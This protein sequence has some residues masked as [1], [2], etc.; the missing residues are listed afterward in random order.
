MRAHEIDWESLPLGQ[1]TDAEI[2]RSLAEKGHTV[3]HWTVGRQRRRL[4]I[5]QASKERRRKDPRLVKSKVISV[6][7][8]GFV[9][10]SLIAEAADRQEDSK[11]KITHRTV[12]S[13]ILE[14]WVAENYDDESAAEDGDAKEPEQ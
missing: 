2:Q 9:E 8:T 12:A 11:R 3:S 6:R 4:G 5:A 13:Q 14:D 7:T 1:E 10:E